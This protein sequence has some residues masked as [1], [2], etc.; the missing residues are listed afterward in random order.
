MS[1]LLN[2][3][4]TTEFMMERGL[5]QRDQ[6]SPFLFNLV[7]ECLSVCL[8]K[9]GD[10]N[11]VRGLISINP[12]WL[13]WGKK[14][15]REDEWVAVFKYKEAIRPITYLGMP[16]GARPSSKAFWNSVLS[17]IQKRLAP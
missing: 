16:L 5:L 12:A 14:G 11:M 17:R 8:K 4:P 1:M 9:A 6:L 10:L 13:E 3:S 15:P 7:M 2:G